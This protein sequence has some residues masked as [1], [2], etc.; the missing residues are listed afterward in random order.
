MAVALV[1]VCRCP[2]PGCHGVLWARRRGLTMLCACNGVREDRWDGGERKICGARYIICELDIVV[3]F[4]DAD[5]ELQRIAIQSS[6]YLIALQ[7]RGK[8]KEELLK[9]P[10]SPDDISKRVFGEV[11]SGMLSQKDADTLME[12]IDKINEENKKK[13]AKPVQEKKAQIIP[14]ERIQEE[15]ERSEPKSVDEMLDG[16]AKKTKKGT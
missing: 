16:V 4:D 10:S 15:R 3:R 8:S 7:Q 1:Y 13:D 5:S 14:R 6:H 2:E 11:K 12:A 9:N